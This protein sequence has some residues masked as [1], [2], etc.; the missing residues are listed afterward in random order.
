MRRLTT[1]AM[2]LVLLGGVVGCGG[3][4]ESSVSKQQAEYLASTKGEFLRGC[5]V[6]AGVS[7]RC[8]CILRHVEAAETER[9]YHLT[10]IRERGAPASQEP[11]HAK[12]FA[13]DCSGQ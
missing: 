5:E 3:G 13:E 2:V 8:H 1:L 10:V 4:S 6:V 9:E 11:P 12:E 7:S